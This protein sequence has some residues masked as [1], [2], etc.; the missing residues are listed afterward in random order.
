MSH[1]RSVYEYFRKYDLPEKSKTE[2][3]WIRY[4]EAVV[5]YGVT[6][7]TIIRWKRDIE[8]QLNKKITLK[9]DDIVLINSDYIEEFLE[10]KKCNSARD[11]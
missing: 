5:R 8:K 1:A 4:D 10:S 3:R 6:R 2:K 9:S 7:N 11:C